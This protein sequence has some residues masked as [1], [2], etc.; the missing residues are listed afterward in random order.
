MIIVD[1]REQDIKHIL[2]YFDQNNIEYVRQ[3]L[4]VGDYSTPEQKVIVER[5]RVGEL[6]GNLTGKDKDRFYRE[7]K[8]AKGYKMIIM[9][10]GSLEDIQNRNYRCRISPAD[11]KKRIDTWANHFM[12]SVHFVT[13]ETAGQFI[14]D[15]LMG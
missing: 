9:V 8:R 2:A 3:K 12:F 1:T 11:F 6:A 10:E 13:K 5:K 14:L 15:T 4:N 7:F